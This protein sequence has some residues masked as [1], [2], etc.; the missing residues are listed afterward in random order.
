MLLGAKARFNDAC[1]IMMLFAR[2]HIFKKMRS[3]MAMQTIHQT[4]LDDGSSP[5]YY[6]PKLRPGK[7][8]PPSSF[9]WLRL[10]L[11]SFSKRLLSCSF[12]VLIYTLT[13]RKTS[14]NMED[15]R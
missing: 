1:A 9:K 7:V 12:F 4:L 11:L 5:N 13:N 10:L 2:R 14:Q 6:D 15:F 8:F 3:P